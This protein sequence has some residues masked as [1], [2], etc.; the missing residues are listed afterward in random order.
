MTDFDHPGTG[1]GDIW[2]S[3]ASGAISTTLTLVDR[4]AIAVAI[5]SA[6][7]VGDAFNVGGDETSERLLHR[8][9]G[10]VKI[11]HDSENPRSGR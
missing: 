10:G 9:L 11:T 7:L 2:L 4:N 3:S 5:T 1:T 6:M 8:V